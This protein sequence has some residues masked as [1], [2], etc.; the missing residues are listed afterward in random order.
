MGLE[1]G[2][3]F[4]F[5]CCGGLIS[6]KICVIWELNSLNYDVL[7]ML[8]LRH[9]TFDSNGKGFFDVTIWATFFSL[10]VLVIYS[11][12]FILFK[13]GGRNPSQIFRREK[14][15]CELWTFKLCISCIVTDV[16]TDLDLV[17][18]NSNKAPCYC[19]YMKEA[20]MYFDKM[21]RLVI[22]CHLHSL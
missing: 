5:L 4:F 14:W 10:I 22:V 9:V 6:I 2:D 1:F 13:A 8:V 15:G 12:L 16:S 7:S 20:N 3:C 21:Y 11:F 18:L 19:D 17:L